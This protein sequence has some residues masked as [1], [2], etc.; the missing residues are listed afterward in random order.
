[1]KFKEKPWLGHFGLIRM[2]LKILGYGLKYF[3]HFGLGL[4]SVLTS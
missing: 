3:E 1:M 4:E 2:F